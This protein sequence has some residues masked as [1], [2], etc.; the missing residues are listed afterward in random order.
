MKRIYIIF[1]AALLLSACCD[2][3][4]ATMHEDTDRVELTLRFPSMQKETVDS[5]ANTTII[6]GVDNLWVFFYGSDSRFMSK[7]EIESEDITFDGTDYRLRIII[8]TGAASLSVVANA[9]TLMAT[10]DADRPMSEVKINGP[11]P[12]TS[13]Q[14][15][16]GTV[17]IAQIKSTI[18]TICLT[19]MVAKTS[20]TSEISDFDII[21]VVSYY[22][23]EAGTVSKSSISQN[24]HNAETKANKTAEGFVWY[25]YETTYGAAPDTHAKILIHASYKGREGYYPIS[26][27][28]D[29]SDE[30]LPL[31]R[32]HHY[33][34]RITKV[35]AV[36]YETLDEALAAEPE[37]RLAVEVRDDHDAIYDMIACKDYELG[38]GKE[39]ICGWDRVQAE[40]SFVTTIKDG[41][42]KIDDIDCSWCT[43]YEIVSSTPIISDAYHS[44]GVMRVLRL[45]LLP[46]DA[47]EDGR[48]FD[49]TI[50]SGDLTRTVTVTQTGRDF[51]RDDM[52]PVEIKNLKSAGVWEDYFNFIDNELNGVR[53]DDMMGVERNQGL[54]FSVGQ[55]KYEYRIKKLYSTESVVNTDSR[56]TVIEENGYWIVRLTDNNQSDEMWVSEFIINTP[57]RISITYPVYRT[58]VIDNIESSESNYQQVSNITG[59][60][61]YE[62]VKVRGR[63]IYLLDRN[64]GATTNEFYSPNVAELSD[65]R[66]AVGG[67]FKISFEKPSNVELDGTLSDNISPDGYT[68]PDNA[69]SFK[70]LVKVKS[71]R[72]IGN[73]LY[74]VYYIETESASIDG[75]T[76]TETY[77]PISGYYEGT[78]HKNTSHACL[79]SKEC[80]SGAQGFDPTSPEYKYWYMYITMYNQTIGISN[81]RFVNGGAGSSTGTGYKGM[82]VRCIRK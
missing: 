69:E 1:L 31:E 18:T 82:P 47:S 5:R 25:N 19:R 36:G 28:K 58:G 62:Q 80:L 63:N 37:N 53:P 27:Y 74:N 54:H 41:S 76:N 73:V 14:I 9:G 33:T 38:V 39:V 65:S 12:V 32:N 56:F 21:D 75:M 81:M 24:N 30:H 20:L 3:S 45:A 77:I 78:S 16:H 57:Q 59:W 23:A 26:Y 48:S 15:M 2:D 55:N 35:N 43:G 6:P 4:P 68:L 34:I 60:Y 13:N 50:S 29:E 44:A 64:L 71:K 49:V 67:Y 22:A 17:T 42:Y 52:R 79:W 61:Y 10:D 66:G 46:N 72:T 7:S 51:K 11:L 40:F 70:N 8:P